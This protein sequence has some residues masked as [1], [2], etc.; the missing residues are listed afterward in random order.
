[1]FKNNHNGTTKPGV[2][3]PSPSDSEKAQA[4]NGRKWFD[5][6]LTV[7]T[8]LKNRGF[9]FKC[10]TR[11]PGV[12]RLIVIIPN[13]DVDEVKISRKILSLAFSRRLDVFLVTLVNDSAYESM[14]RR[15]LVT[16]MTLL[17]GSLVNVKV[18]VVLGKSWVETIGQICADGDIVVCPEELTASSR[19]GIR[20]P[21]GEVIMNKYK[22][23][24]VTYAGF[25]NDE[26]LN[27]SWFLHNIPY[28]II[29]IT[30]I[31]GFFTFELDINLTTMGR[32]GQILLFLI[33]IIEIG[34]IYYWTSISG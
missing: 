14:A 20:K 28:W 5:S 32:M 4:T 7:N 27:H 2:S 3:S 11:L 25:F 13:Q 33:V 23:P 17:N 1:M 9:R 10:E 16:M 30:L 15:R 22:L 24:V 8:H 21:L 19:I 29:I 34:V 12:R 18:E 26:Y 6:P 31:V